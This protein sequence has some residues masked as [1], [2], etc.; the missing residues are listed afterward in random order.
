[1]T[2]KSNQFIFIPNCTKVENLVKFPQA[3]YNYKTSC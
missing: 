2:S 1:M 3:V